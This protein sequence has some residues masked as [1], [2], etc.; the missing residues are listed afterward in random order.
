MYLLGCKRQMHLAGA[1]KFSEAL[2][3]PADDFLHA[4]IRIEAETDLP[5]PDIAD[6][7]GNSEFT[8]SG[9]RPCGIQ[10]P[11]S[12]NAEFKLADAALHAQEQAVIRPTWVIDTIGVYNTGV[13][14]TAQ[15]EQMMPIPAVTGETGGV[16][17]KHST[18]LAGTESGDELVE[19]RARHG[20]AGRT[21]QIIVDD[22]DI[23]KSPAACFIDEVILAALTF[24]MHLD[25]SLG[26]L[27]HIHHR[28]AAQH[29]RRQVIRIHHC[30][31]PPIPRRR[32][33]SEFA[34]DDGSRCCDRCL[35]SR[36][37][38]LDPAALRIDGVA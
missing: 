34:Q 4:A 7:H 3:D 24:E 19:A 6:R 28:L 14:Q 1:A 26:R 23:L 36:S 11:R 33:P 27:P 20:S 16:E 22:L 8:P 17:A 10:H 13:D 25:L 38:S 2:E 35:S 18:N 21:A 29:G 9:L 15:L 37:I 5:M 32:P 31:S 12:Q 30:R